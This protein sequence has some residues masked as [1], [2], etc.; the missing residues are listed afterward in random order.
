MYK[1]TAFLLLCMN[2]TY[3]QQRD[4]VDLYLHVDK[5][6]YLH[7][8]NIWFTAY[9]LNNPAQEQHTLYTLLVN[10]SSKAIVATQRF[11][12]SSGLAGGSVFLPDSIP[13][14]N[15]RL[16]AYT[17]SYDAILGRLP[18]H[19]PVSLVS[20]T[21]RRNKANGIQKQ[22]PAS[23][24]VS[25]VRVEI[26][27]DSANYHKRSKVTLNFKATDL[28]G[29]PV[30]AFFSMACVLSSRV[31]AGMASAITDPY[32]AEALGHFVSSSDPSVNTYPLPSAD[33]GIVLK[34][35]KRLKKPVLLLVTGGRSSRMI[36]TDSLGRFTVPADLLK[37]D[38]GQQVR[39]LLPGNK[40]RENGYQPIYPSR[41][42]K[43]D[44]I[45]A[46]Y[47]FPATVFYDDEPTE[48]EVSAQ[49]KMLKAVVVTAKKSDEYQSI[50]VFK[51]T[52]CR[53]W[54]CMNNILNCKNHP[55]GYK[56]IHGARYMYNGG[57]PVRYEGCNLKGPGETGEFVKII[58]PICYPKEYYVAD[59]SKF[60][61]DAPEVLSTLYWSYKVI[62]DING[63]ATVSFYTN[64]IK[65]R[66]VCSIQGYSDEGPFTAKTFF[67]V[68]E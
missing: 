36:S 60:N 3:G 35:G 43:M 10:D 23:I 53:D 56:P 65:G 27:T 64:D 18:F 30:N 49:K 13:A 57:F 54:V 15:Y 17:N 14:G 34:N 42:N 39:V 37:A 66:F 32:R 4:V 33:T 22:Q 62:T 29:K 67:R 9:V 44:S 6:V 68:I 16:I 38:N 61:P 63:E 48:A 59:Y 20:P 45:L 12:I 7:N 28:Q 55:S 58:D 25:P 40:D 1:L 11:V 2:F 46:S 51:S 19:C 31:D 47:N 8:E 50:D 52:T 41:P 21:R 5:N 26:E 24:N